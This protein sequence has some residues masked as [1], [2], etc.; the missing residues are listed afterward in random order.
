M[1]FSHAVT[2]RIFLPN[3]KSKTNHIFK[4]KKLKGILHSKD[5]NALCFIW[6]SHLRKIAQPGGGQRTL[7]CLKLK[8]DF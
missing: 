3:I 7:L 4:R 2:F 6:K 5:P 8:Q 1:G